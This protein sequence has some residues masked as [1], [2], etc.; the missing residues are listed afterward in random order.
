[1]CSVAVARC[2]YGVGAVVAVIAVVADAV[3]LYWPGF[4]FF[5]CKLLFSD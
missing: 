4:C 1:M 5:C 3:A 2:G